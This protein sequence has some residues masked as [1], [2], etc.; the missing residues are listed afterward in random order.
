MLLFR[1]MGQIQ[2]QNQGDLLEVHRNHHGTDEGT[3]SGTDQCWVHFEALWTG[4]ADGWYVEMEI[5]EF[6]FLCEPL[7][8]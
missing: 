6:F 5:A 8:E 2:G 4:F 3:S 7:E 1:E